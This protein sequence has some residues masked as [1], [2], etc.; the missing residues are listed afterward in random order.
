MLNFFGQMN[1]VEIPFGNNVRRVAILIFNDYL[2]I[3]NIQCDKD[4][5]SHYVEHKV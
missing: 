1:G 2:C 3:S 4:G 5:R